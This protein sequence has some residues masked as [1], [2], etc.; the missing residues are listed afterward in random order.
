[1]P[2]FSQWILLS[3]SKNETVIQTL[4]H[5]LGAFGQPG[6]VVC[7]ADKGLNLMNS[8]KDAAHSVEALG[9]GTVEHYYW[10]RLTEANCGGEAEWR[11]L[12]NESSWSRDLSQLDILPA[13]WLLDATD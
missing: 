5:F 3:Y 7:L 6:I 12:A 2:C 4:K 8:L 1:M 13:N 10:K 11:Q 9:R